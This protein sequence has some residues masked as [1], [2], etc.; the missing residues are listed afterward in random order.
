MSDACARSLSPNSN[1][2]ARA[3]CFTF[4]LTLSGEPI[5]ATTAPEPES[6]TERIRFTVNG[7]AREIDVR[8]EES[9]VE[10]LRDRLGLTGTKLV[11]GEGVCGACTV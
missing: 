3:W 6:G 2:A 8:P 5:S 1:D 7:L 11:C 9:A 4:G 10:V